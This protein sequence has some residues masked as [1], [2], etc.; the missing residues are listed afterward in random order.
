[1]DNPDVD[2]S[3]G[4]KT[5]A[6]GTAFAEGA[7]IPIG[8]ARIGIVD[9]G[10]L[11]SDAT[12]DVVHVWNGCFFRLEDH[13][14]R[15]LSGVERLRMTLPYD[16]PE[17]RT[18]LSR[19][20]SLTGL[21]NAY[22]EV[23]CTRGVPASGSR[24]PRTCVNRFYAFAIPFVWIA[25]PAAQ[26][27]GLSAAISSVQRI[28]PF[29]VDPTIKNYHWLDLTRGLFE[30]YDQGCETAVLI[31]SAG[32]IAEGPGFNVFVVT[33]GRLLTPGGGV[34][35]GITRRTV[36]EIAR[37]LGLPVEVATLSA[38]ELRSA[39]EAFLTSTAG[40]VIPITRVNRCDIAH[41]TPGPITRRLR[42]LYWLAHSDPQ[43][44]TA[45]DYGGR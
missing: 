24:D 15:F 10:F 23:I 17:L 22:V 34:L 9:W 11:H 40:G 8:E 41:G 20:V 4:S 29:S 44:S 19:C 30:A 33:G 32:N 13:L 25:D 21:R 28:S 1:M 16:R 43:F 42:E 2:R 14:D 5:F 26:E 36:L 35:K 3:D 18:I 7:Y 27:R 12:Y 38:N 45:V 6:Q 37:R 39:D 31:D